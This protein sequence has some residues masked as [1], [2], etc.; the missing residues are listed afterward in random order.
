MSPAL[1]DYWKKLDWK[2][3]YV[4]VYRCARIQNEKYAH[5]LAPY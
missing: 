5:F 3:I 4:Y 2:E 1:A